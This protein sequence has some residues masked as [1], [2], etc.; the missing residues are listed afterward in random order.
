MSFT[1]SGDPKSSPLD[2]ARFA[3]GDTVEEGALMQDAEINYILQEAKSPSHVLAM[4][5][6]HAA[7]V[8]GGRL[9]K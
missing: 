8:Y 9:V 6:R 1:Y 7:T 5:F 4:L 3:I 2:A